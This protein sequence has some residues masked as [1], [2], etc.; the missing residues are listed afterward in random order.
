MVL[1]GRVVKKIH[2]TGTKSLHEAVYLTSPQGDFKLR[3][4]GANPFRDPQLDHLVG[5][6]ISAQG[7]VDKVSNQF[8]VSHWSELSLSGSST[9]PGKS[10]K[11]R[12]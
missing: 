3:L 6:S 2:G 5:K 9:P 7:E 4:P 8:F 1:R 10:R 11:S 12:Q